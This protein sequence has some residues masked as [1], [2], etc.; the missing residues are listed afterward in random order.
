MDETKV[1]WVEHMEI[2]LGEWMRHPEI[3]WQVTGLFDTA[4]WPCFSIKRGLL[5]VLGQFN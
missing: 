3:L 5:R 2:N 1:T 4:P